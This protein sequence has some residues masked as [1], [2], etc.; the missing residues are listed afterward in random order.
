MAMRFDPDEIIKINYRDLTSRT[1]GMMLISSPEIL[2]PIKQARNAYELFR[3]N[4]DYKGLKI[5]KISL[6]NEKNIFSKNALQTFKVADLRTWFN[7]KWSKKKK[8]R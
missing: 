4:S 7:K 5:E 3:C 6:I 2:S 1:T 8:S